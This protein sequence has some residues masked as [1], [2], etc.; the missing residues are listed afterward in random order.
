MCI[1]AF[2][3]LAC[4]CLTATLPKAGPDRLL[5]AAS[6]PARIGSN[7]QVTALPPMPQPLDL[8]EVSDKEARL[9]NARTPFASDFGPVAPPFTLRGDTSSQIRAADCLAAAMWYEAG[10][11]AI[12]QL[13]VGQVVLN[14]V[15]HLAF[16]GTVCGVV[17]QG[18]DRGIGC[19][20]TFTCDG[21]MHRIPGAAQFAMARARAQQM[22]TGLVMSQVGLATHYHTDWVHPRWS[23]EMDK[24]AAVGGHLFMRWHGNWGGIAAYRRHYSGNEPVVDAMAVLPFA[25][26]FAANE[27]VPKDIAVPQAVIATEA[28]ESRPASPANPSANSYTIEMVRGGDGGRQAFA[29]VG[30]CA[31]HDLCKVIGR[32]SGM[33]DVAFVYLKSRR[34]KWIDAMFWNCDIFPRTNPK[35]CIGP[36]QSAKL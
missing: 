14:R 17:F 35:E 6:D 13:A 11:D 30:K 27:S 16:P 24:L 7:L 34:G 29:A 4:L 22:L 15:R 23:P 33:P 5:P 31:A 26:T 1:A 28:T 19:Q 18:S 21:A 32:V 10:N 20:F 9:I 8:D 3:C 36:E 25:S 2:A 12:G